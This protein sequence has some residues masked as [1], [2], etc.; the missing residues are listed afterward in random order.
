M[1]GAHARDGLIEIDAR[2]VDASES[3]ARH[4]VLVHLLRIDV[5]SALGRVERR[6]AI[7]KAFLHE[8]VVEVPVVVRSDSHGNV[9]RPLPVALGYHL[10][11]HHLALIDSAL[12]LQA[13][14]HLVGDAV[15]RYHHAAAAD[16]VLVDGEDDAVGRYEAQLGVVAEHPVVDDALQLERVIAQQVAKRLRVVLVGFYEA[17][18]RAR[19]DG[20][21]LASACH[22]LQAAPVDGHCRRVVGGALHLV[23]VPVGLQIG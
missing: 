3:K 18:Q 8:V 15:A 23:D 22:V 13:D 1:G 12:A 5:H 4:E 16:S 6:D 9:E 11:H 7:D 21:A 20:D 14:V 2:L 19:S 17:L 10:V